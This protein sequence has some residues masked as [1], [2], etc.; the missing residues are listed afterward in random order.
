MFLNPIP[1]V[2]IGAFFKNLSVFG[3]LYKFHLT[4]RYNKK[5]IMMTVKTGISIPT[6]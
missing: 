1:L 2:K 3:H 5:I 4:Y 6:E